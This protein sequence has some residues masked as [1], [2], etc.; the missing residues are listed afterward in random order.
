LCP[1]S[2]YWANIFGSPFNI[3]V[4][5]APTSAPSSQAWGDGIVR[6]EAGQVS[7]VHLRARDANFNKRGEGGDGALGVRVYHSSMQRFHDADITDQGDGEY[8]LTFTAEKSGPTLVHVTLGG[9]HWDKSPYSIYV[10]YTEP[11]GPS[12]L[13]RGAG[14]VEAISNIPQTIVVEVKDP[15]SNTR[16]KGGDTAALSLRLDLADTAGVE[17]HA[18]NARALLGQKP[19]PV[20]VQGSA[21]TVVD[22]GD[23]TYTMTYVATSAGDCHL[24]VLTDANFGKTANVTVGGPKVAL[25]PKWEHFG[26]SPFLVQVR[27]GPPR[28]S[29]SSATG[30]GLTHAVAGDIATFVVQAIDY[31]GNHKTVDD[32]VV[33]VV[34]TGQGPND[35]VV[36]NPSTTHTVTTRNLNASSVVNGTIRYIGG[37]KYQC[38]YNAT[39]SGTNTL[40]ITL[41][42][43]PI[44]GSPFKPVVVHSAAYAATSVATG[45]GLCVSSY[46]HQRGRWS[47]VAGRVAPVHIQARDRYG[48]NLA[49]GGDRFVVR[50][51][52]A[53]LAVGNV[54]GD[55][56]SRPTALSTDSSL[57]GA[58]L[59]TYVPAVVDTGDGTYQAPYTPTVASST[60]MMRVDLATKGGLWMEIFKTPQPIASQRVVPPALDADG[61]P[62]NMWT[63]HVTQIRVEP[64]VDYDWGSLAPGETTK[65]KVAAA[66]AKILAGETPENFNMAEVLDVTG[67]TATSVTR[68]LPLIPL[69]PRLG[70][71]AAW[72]GWLQ[73]L[74]GTEPTTFILTSTGGVTLWVDGK[75]LAVRTKAGKGYETSMHW[76]NNSNHV[77]AGPTEVGNFPS[78]G[79]A[80]IRSTPLVLPTDRLVPIRIEYVD[81]GVANTLKLEWVSASSE[82]H[83]IKS[84]RFFRLIPVG[85]APFFSSPTAATVIPAP[86]SSKHTLAT[87]LA[88]QTSVSG[89]E[90]MFQVQARDE[91]GNDQVTKQFGCKLVRVV[92]VVWCGVVWKEVHAGTE[93]TCALT[94]NGINTCVFV[95]VCVIGVCDWCVIGVCD[96][97][98]CV[99]VCVCDWCV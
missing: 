55:A 35:G 17:G 13:A 3:H 29:N 70:W 64:T 6:A 74:H 57:G 45:D 97:C 44:H 90:S 30:L 40:D 46:T 50:L 63:A 22:H 82:R 60:Y 71:S 77:H 84:D 98:V 42:D 12:S 20:L 95:C 54:K 23:G 31:R 99:C 48:N 39:V 83:V 66:K 58:N 89:V 94:T 91:F 18:D 72:H 1:G 87:G 32:S 49:R 85:R 14:L 7:T 81:A 93:R 88:L 16:Y 26:N 34:V 28:A 62:L 24:S 78:D 86:T 9:H 52:P 65:E 11:D 21:S 80:E 53:A 27:D 92:V 15:F 8:R 79:P 59:P 75:Q 25:S 43:K 96:W 51:L 69:I 73:P 47:C 10:D 4:A 2:W 67:G 68:N 5:P 33:K 37:G 76:A 38:T 61:N 41:D 56:F 19:V 36:V